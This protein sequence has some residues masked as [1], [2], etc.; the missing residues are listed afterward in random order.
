MRGDLLVIGF[1]LTT[2]RE[3]HVADR[4][5]A[6]WR[7]MGY[8]AA[9]TLVC[10][11]CLHGVDAPPGTRVPL[12][13]KGRIGG[14]IRT[15]FAHPPGMAPAGGHHAETVWHI[16]AKHLL[17]RWAR[18]CPGVTDVRL[19]HWTPDQERRADV[20]VRL[21]DG[22][23]VALEAQQAQLTDT[24]WLARHRDYEAAGI[25]DVWFWHKRVRP[26]SAQKPHWDD[27]EAWTHSLIC[28]YAV[29]V[30]RGD[31]RR[32]ARPLA[33]SQGWGS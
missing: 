7:P 6:Q 12:I 24:A 8:G 28:C 11:Y 29:V 1:D 15:H 13:T 9:E 16:T 32:I 26:T 25:R 27:L 31:R 14:R 3:V 21:A 2:G 10:L 19:E 17:A 23:R 18:V 20:H 22:S 30:R 33:W 5:A 4:S